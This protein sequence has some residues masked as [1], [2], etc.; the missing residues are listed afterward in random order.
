M[1]RAWGQQA[2]EEIRIEAPGDVRIELVL[3]PYLSALTLMFD[4]LGG[5]NRGVSPQWRQQIRAS[6]EPRA[7]RAV[8]PLVVSGRSRQPDCV[9]APVPSYRDTTLGEV[10][11]RLHDTSGDELCATLDH[12]HGERLPDCWRGPVK[13][14]RRWLDEFAD[15]AATVGGV[16][17]AKWS[18]AKPLLDAEIHRVGTAAVR[19]SLDVV[20]ASIHPRA[21]YADG[22]LWLPAIEAGRYLVTA[23]RLVLVPMI[24]GMLSIAH[25]L[26]NPDVAW[27][28]YPVPGLTSL[29]SGDLSR[30]APG[31]ELVNLLGPARAAILRATTS[32]VALGQ[33]ADAVAQTPSSASRHTDRLIDAGL[34]HRRR[35]GKSVVI[36][37]TERGDALMDLYTRR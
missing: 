1:A 30:P 27:I 3:N 12:I 13:Q 9:V 36:A 6:A 15:A 26:D 2:W 23:R 22:A 14:P 29:W 37:R 32:H 24:S 7:F 10:V 25:D 18:A 19:G 33:L 8:A 28:S 20:L 16:L 4:A 34:L 35:A 17:G 5:W 21:R 11:E 31:D